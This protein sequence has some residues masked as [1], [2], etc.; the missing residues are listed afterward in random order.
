[1]RRLLVRTA[2]A[3]LF[4]AGVLAAWALRPEPPGFDPEPLLRTAAQYEVR[5]LRDAFG[6]PHVYGARDRDV[7]YGLGFA[8]SEDDF[9]T[10][11]RVTLAARGRLASVDGP[12]AAPLDYLVALMDVWGDV[13]ARYASDLSPETR[14]LAEAYAAGV[15]H[16]A[17]LHPE[18]TLPGAIP[19]TGRDVVAGFAFRTPFFYGFQRAVAELFGLEKPSGGSNAVAV[20]P[21]RSSD[22]ATRLLVNSHQPYTGPVAW[23]EVRL[24]SEEGWDVTGGVFPGSPVILHGSNRVL[25]W[26]NTVNLPDLVDVYELEMHPEDDTRYRF[27]GEWRRLE[28]EDVR[29]PVRLFGRLHWTVTRRIARSVHGPVVRNDAGH[30]ALRWVGM[31]E[32]RQLEQ[33][34]RLNKAR[35]FE[36]WRDAMRMQAFPSVNYVY[37]DAQGNIAY[38]YNAKFPRRTPGYDWRAHLP[39]DRADALWTEFLPFEAVPQVVNPASGFVAS[40]NHTPFRV[41]AGADNPDPADYPDWLGIEQTMTNRAFRALELYGSDSRI[42]PDEFKSYS[43]DK[44]YSEASRARSIVEAIRAADPPDEPL[45]RE[46]RRVLEGWSL[47][48]DVDDRGAALGILTATPIVL[49]ERLGRPAP[50]PVA[51]LRD[52]AR[53]LMEHHGRLDPPWGRI[54]RLRRGAL[55]LPVGGGPDLLRA[56]ESFVLED[57]GTYTALSGDSLV[58]FVEWSA[59]GEWRVESI[60]QFGSATLDSRSPHYADQTPLFAAEQTKVVPLEEA[61]LLAQAERAYRP[62][63]RVY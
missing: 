18:E 54:N 17:A 13:D 26:A 6:V 22:G 61:E 12:G 63:E 3:L 59:A 42:G 33:L 47:S 50:D 39:G 58:M 48:A 27:E 45:L 37:A 25:G 24:K 4:A 49:A 46:A 36:E 57:D 7:A 60:H 41:T 44:R 20:A 30:F 1:M 52:A 15:N 35:S 9:P 16:Y 53:S 55:D 2:L 11:Q 14:A 31:G 43:Y 8:H 23:Y 29:I 19:A 28:I 40:A 10:I 32:I 56:I 34:Y 38:F 5:I 62:G 51:A 21:S